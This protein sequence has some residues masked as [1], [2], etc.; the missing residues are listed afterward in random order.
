MTVPDVYYLVFVETASNQTYI[1]GSNRL[2]EN[3]GASQLVAMATEDWPFE[4]LRNLK[5]NHN[6]LDTFSHEHG[7][8]NPDVA[9]N[10]NT[11]D[12]E[13]IYASG[14]NFVALFRHQNLA[15]EFTRRLSRKVLISAP[16]VQLII[17]HEPFNWRTQLL[18]EAVGNIKTIAKKRMTCVSLPLLGLGITQM[19]ASTSLPAVQ[20]K[21]YSDANRDALQPMSA[22]IKAKH[23]GVTQQL[24]RQKLRDIIGDQY[25]YREDLGELGIS[26]GE[27][28]Y[29]AV[30]HADGNGIG[31]ALRCFLAQSPD[32][33]SYIK[34]MRTF[35]LALNQV[36]R[37]ALRSMIDVLKP[38]HKEGKIPAPNGSSVSLRKD[39]KDGRFI[40]PLRPIVFG[41]DD[42]T[43]VSEGRL[44]LFLARTYLAAFEAAA[45]ADSIL[46]PYKITASAG[47]AIV[48]LKYPFARAYDLVDELTAS[49]KSL[50]KNPDGTD[51]LIKDKD[52]KDNPIKS[53][54]DWYFAT[55]GLYGDLKTMRKHEY[56]VT[57]GSL[58]LRPIVLSEDQDALHNWDVIEKGLKAFQSE[59]W[60]D[61]RNKSKG[62]YKALRK[63]EIDVQRFLQVYDLVHDM[64]DL[65]IGQEHQKM[66]WVKNV[67]ANA[68]K[69][70][71]ICV[72]FDALEL[73]D[74]YAP[75]LVQ[76]GVLS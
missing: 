4:I 34:N 40:L 5:V 6:L 32:N 51:K 2:K 21:P 52:G 56:H 28:S 44:G 30:V 18:N 24:A 17:A 1:F 14:G 12:V 11:L 20:L 41:G 68:A 63:G 71:K 10:E 75:V 59:T 19:C 16:G 37:T 31:A 64:P 15:Q 7:F 23:E 73:M 49:A 42:V 72:Y 69:Y 54:L 50:R 46:G 60:A 65:G 22:E 27:R 70:E 38:F 8:Y 43:F 13:V 39:E 76:G 66:G 9:I 33:R 3:V 35:S 57:A 29:M 74:I 47:V 25:H 61:R 48:K 26:E 62:L 36:A 53:T 67:A 58:T 55:G 45:Q